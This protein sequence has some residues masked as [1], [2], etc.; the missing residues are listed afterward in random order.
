LVEHG[1]GRQPSHVLARC[2]RTRP[3]LS[4]DGPFSGLAACGGILQFERAARLTDSRAAS[5]RLA[6][7]TRSYRHSCVR[8]ASYR[9]DT[10]KVGRCRS[11]AVDFRLWR[12]APPKRPDET[13]EWTIL[14]PRSMPGWTSGIGANC[15]SCSAAR[16][17][18]TA[19]S[20][21]ATPSGSILTA[22]HHAD[23]SPRRW[24]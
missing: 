6:G 11:S 20:F 4:R 5:P 2:A 8:S 7:C 13:K 14:L 16:P 10:R 1:A 17:R 12:P 19:H 21:W 24:S 15:Y 9:R 22:S 18:V 3:D 23:S